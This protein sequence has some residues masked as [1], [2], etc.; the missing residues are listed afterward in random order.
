MPAPPY[1][2]EKG[3]HSDYQAFVVEVEIAVDQYGVPWSN[4]KLQDQ[5]DHEITSTMKSGG[6]EH[7]AH[8]LINEAVKREALLEVLIR[9]S[10][11][12]EFQGR[13]QD[14]ASEA[15]SDLEQEVA[16][17]IVEVFRRAAHEL[18]PEAARA[19]LNV[20]RSTPSNE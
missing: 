18:A 6:M 8:A 14:E 13:I 9:M 16:G 3:Q 12:P 15:Q 20:V 19:A 2:W 5:R 4:H 7:V 17:A 11:D 10:N 1:P